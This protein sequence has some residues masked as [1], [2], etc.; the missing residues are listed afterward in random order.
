MTLDDPRFYDLCNELCRGGS[1]QIAQE[2]AY[3]LELR[4][5]REKKAHDS[6]QEKEKRPQIVK[7]AVRHGS[8]KPEVVLNTSKAGGLRPP[9]HP[10]SPV[11]RPRRNPEEKTVTCEGLNLSSPAELNLNKSV[12]NGN[13]KFGVSDDLSDFAIRARF[14]EQIAKLNE[15]LAA[16]GMP[17]L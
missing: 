5:E 1:E 2:R 14:A 8:S 6:R 10:V 7:E 16:K 11:S 15:Y 17:T 3:R 13:R 9:G 4:L 12:P